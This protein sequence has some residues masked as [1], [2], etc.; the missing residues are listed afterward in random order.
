MSNTAA[1]NKITSRT[2]N[3]RAPITIAVTP[4]EPAGI[5]PDITIAVATRHWDLRLVAI[6]DPEVIAAR[7]ARLGVPLRIIELPSVRDAHPH[8]PGTLQIIPLQ[9]HNPTVEGVT[10]T[11]NADYVLASLDIAIEACKV[12]DAHAVVTGPVHKAAINDAGITFTGHT[13]YLAQKLGCAAPVM[14]LMNDNLRVAL[15]TTHVSL[16]QVPALITAQRI[17]TV[18]STAHRELQDR[19]AIQHPVIAVCGLNPHAGE[20]GHLGDEELKV[21]APALAS[22][23][24][25]DG[26][27]LSGPLPADT[28]FVDGYR[29]KFDLIVAMYHD[30]GLSALK[31]LGF[32]DTVNVTLGLPIIRT[33]VDHGTALDLAGTGK[34]DAR[35]LSA[36]L[37]TAHLMAARRQFARDD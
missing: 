1:T 19:F 15:V 13:E 37:T 14:M 8:T 32:G 7:A 35:S 20:G 18:I 25:Q 26:I 33:S 12:H 10:D 4:G 34:A 23:R 22:L 16:A 28:V 9:A 2:T 27:N 5:G 31:A 11:N 17:R 3:K 30:Q 36:A 29:C 6:C 21:I 24:D